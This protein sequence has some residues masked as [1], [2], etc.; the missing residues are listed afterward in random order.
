MCPVPCMIRVWIR[1]GSRWPDFTHFDWKRGSFVVS[2]MRVLD[3]VSSPPSTTQVPR[4]S[5]EPVSCTFQPAHFQVR[6]C[7]FGSG[8]F[9][10]T[11]SA[12]SHRSNE[13]GEVRKAN[14]LGILAIA[15]IKLADQRHL[16]ARRA[17]N[18]ILPTHDQLRHQNHS[19]SHS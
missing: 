7:W 9:F 13:T 4:A 11:W 3:V 2:S 14:R 12:Q 16:G 1:F 15:F 17:M 18:E 6:R 10:S 5:G 19:I 8:A